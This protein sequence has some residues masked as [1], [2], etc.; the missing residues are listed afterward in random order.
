MS[1]PEHSAE[2]NQGILLPVMMNSNDNKNCDV[3]LISLCTT[4]PNFDGLA[5]GLL[6]LM[7]WNL[8]TE[9]QRLGT[10]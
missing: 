7:W 4:I 10:S 1:H 9:S 2:W 5:L 6:Q 8:L 3:F